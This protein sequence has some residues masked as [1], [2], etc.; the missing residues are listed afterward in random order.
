M[1]GWLGDVCW[2]LFWKILDVE[3]RLRWSLP[4]HLG[5][6]G[7]CEQ[8]HHTCHLEQMAVFWMASKMR[9]WRVED[10]SSVHLSSNSKNSLHLSSISIY[11]SFAQMA[12][13]KSLKMDL[14]GGLMQK[15]VS[16]SPGC[17][18]FGH[19]DADVSCSVFS[20][21]GDSHFPSNNAG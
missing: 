1:D 3:I 5:L 2:V 19:R 17:C 13:I 10:H 14:S 6:G 16:R 20:Y 18:F 11:F 9:C 7:H 21:P 8:I 4:T 12:D 15:N